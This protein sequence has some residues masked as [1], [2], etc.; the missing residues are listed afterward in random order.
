MKLVRKS[1]DIHKVVTRVIPCL[2]QGRL[3]NN[4]TVLTTHHHKNPQPLCARRQLLPPPN[5]RFRSLA[6]THKKTTIFNNCTSSYQNPFYKTSQTHGTN[7]PPP[8]WVSWRFFNAVYTPPL[9]GFQTQ[10]EITFSPLY[11]AII[12]YFVVFIAHTA[13]MWGA[14]YPC[15]P[16]FSARFQ[17]AAVGALQVS[18]R[19]TAVRE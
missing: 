15:P 7:S 1:T 8:T 6:S 9:R 17:L 2:V 18:V 13:V 14:S 12:Y 11:R 19:T 5:R 10:I 4:H 16:N 3:E